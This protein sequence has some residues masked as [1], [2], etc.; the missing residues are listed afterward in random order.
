M[1]LDFA[2]SQIGKPYRW[3]GAGPATYDCS[4][5]TM[6]A[7][8]KA[9]VSMPHSAQYQYDMTARV[10]ISQLQPGD[11]VFFGTPTDVYHVGMYVGGGSMVDAPE[12]GQDVMIQ[13]IYE[14]N[15][16][17]GGRP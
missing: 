13:P 5:L 2:E 9:G 10:P 1:A 11:L 12:T 17:T 7:W 15:L 6:V 14:L 4:G 8:A 16:L 3:G